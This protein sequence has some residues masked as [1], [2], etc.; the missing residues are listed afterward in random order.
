MAASD[1]EICN[2]ALGQLGNCKQIASLADKSNEA[3]ACTLYYA[4]ARDAVLS[5]F[6]WGFATRTIALTLVAEQPTPEWAYSYR[7]PT[8]ALTIVRLP[9][10][11]APL[12]WD[13]PPCGIGWSVKPVPFR[14]VSDA[15]GKLIYANL[16]DATAEY[17]ARIED[18]TQFSEDFVEALACK[19]AAEMAPLVTGGD[20][21]KLGQQA[22]QRYQVALTAA[23]TRAANEEREGPPPDSDLVTARY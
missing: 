12:T 3:R 5:A 7:Y 23:R 13:Y 11:V 14:I 4:G 10:G 22:Y 1:T 6:P 17:T 19:L 15:S 9:S 21:F 16:S 18:P 2:R 20:A 8:D